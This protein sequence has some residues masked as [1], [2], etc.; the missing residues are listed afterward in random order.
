MEEN[1]NR[2]PLLIISLLVLMS[3]ITFVSCSGGVGKTSN[4]GNS[5]LVNSASQVFRD[6]SGL[7]NFRANISSSTAAVGKQEVSGSRS[8]DSYLI[9]SKYQHNNQRENNPCRRHDHSGPA[10]RKCR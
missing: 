10:Y 2:K 8:L 9:Y 1:M 5:V 4:E 7:K 6:I 3:L